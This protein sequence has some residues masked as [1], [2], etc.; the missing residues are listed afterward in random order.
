M[1]IE[2][3]QID[4]EIYPLTYEVIYKYILNIFNFL[5]IFYLIFIWHFYIII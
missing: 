2:I 5:K 1:K 3:N 4:D